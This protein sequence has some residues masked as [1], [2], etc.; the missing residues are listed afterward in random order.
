MVNGPSM[1]KRFS[2]TWRFRQIQPNITEVQFLYNFKV[3]PRF[4][5]WFIEPLIAVV[6]QRSMKRRLLAFKAWAENVT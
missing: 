3:R 1:L 5:G 6:Y 2:G 4:L